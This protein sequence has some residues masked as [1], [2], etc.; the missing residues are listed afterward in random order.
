MKRRI[1]FFAI[2]LCSGTVLAAVPSVKRIEGIGQLLE[3]GALDEAKATISEISS[4]GEKTFWESR[5][6][7]A[8]GD[9]PRALER[10]NEALR[11][12]GEV[13]TWKSWRTLYY[14]MASITMNHQSYASEHFL[15]RAAGVD[16]ILAKYA[17]DCLETAY[18]LVGGEMGVKPED[19]ILVEVYPQ[20]DQ[21]AVASTLGDEVLA[22]SGTVGIC[23]FNRLMILS[24]QALP[25]GYGWLDTLCHEYTHLLVSRR[26]KGNC[27]LWLHEGIARYYD[28]RWRLSNPEF[29][30]TSGE[31]ALAKAQKSGGFI[32]FERMHPSLVYLKDQDEIGLAFAE[33]AHAVD[34]MRRTWGSN[35]P[36]K[37][38]G[39]MTAD[40]PDDAF[41]KSFGITI[42]DFEKKWLA[43]VKKAEFTEMAGALPDQ[44]Q[45]TAKPDDEYVGAD[46]RGIIRIA[47]QMRSLNRFEAALLQYDKARAAEPANPVILLKMARCYIG[48]KRYK[49][50]VT[51]LKI[52]I[53]KNPHYVT[54]YQVL[55]ELYL[56][57][58][59]YAD[60][61]S[62]YMKAMTIN[63]FHP[64]TH[65]DLARC[66]S[67]MNRGELAYAELAICV[68]LDPKD[69]ES[70]LMLERLKLWK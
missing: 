3:C 34:Y 53:D 6:A 63:P 25:L 46:Q 13:D 42:A 56:K 44:P 1:I 4:P 32:T 41:K 8:Q 61:V 23:K 39:A 67:A 37:V 66:Y 14:A 36:G 11:M 5:Y 70:R 27:P 21:F 38:A 65:R 59:M 24:P 35:A 16:G 51:F 20:K 22:K 7:F 52:A 49:D 40:T 19:K 30:G 68:T 50:A 48:L 2:L 54:P 47:D 58:S 18:V 33:V 29:L 64:G 15:F 45:F 62:T 12:G 60:A 55:G 43:S 57:T 69:S 9:Y 28:T 17:L 10:V 26:S 31:N